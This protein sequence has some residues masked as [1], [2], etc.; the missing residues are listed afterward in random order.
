VNP[1]GTLTATLATA[2]GQAAP[3]PTDAQINAWI[4]AGTRHYGSDLTTTLAP[5]S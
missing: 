4:P 1:D 2:S 5:T 3:V